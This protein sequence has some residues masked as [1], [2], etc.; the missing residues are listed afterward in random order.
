[1]SYSNSFSMAAIRPTSTVPVVS[2]FPPKATNVCS[3]SR[4]GRA[5]VRFLAM[6]KYVA[7]SS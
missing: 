7:N 2:M 4:A 6:S 3:T 5:A 1:M